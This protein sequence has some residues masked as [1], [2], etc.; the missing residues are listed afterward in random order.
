MIVYRLVR[1]N[2]ITL[3]GKGAAEYPGRWN[4]EDIP[5]VYTSESSSLA[6][7]EVMA[8]VDDWNIFITVPHVMLQIEVSD[9][10]VVAIDESG[11]P[12]GWDAA[13]YPAATQNFGAEL[14]YKSDV[15]AF[16]VPS[17]VNKLERNIILNPHARDFS[18]GVKVMKKIRFEFDK[19]LMR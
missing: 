13:I 9:H 14:L 10:R 7:L 18:T 8:N 17:A 3:D 1:K 16:S 19:R 2:R 6:Q 5:C 15:L 4:K 11:L 12:K